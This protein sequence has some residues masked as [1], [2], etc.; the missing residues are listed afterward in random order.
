LTRNSRDFEDVAPW[1]AARGRR[2]LAVDVRG[3]GRS[4]RDPNPLNYQPPVYAGDV[5]SLMMQAGVGRAVFVGTSMGGLITMTLA[6][7]NPLAVAAAVLND[8][9]PELSPVGLTRIMGYVG[10]TAPVKTW[11]EAADY[12][13]ATNGVAFPNAGPEF[14]DAFARRIFRDGP[15][16]PELDY[17]PAITAPFKAAPTGPAPDLWPIFAALAQNRPTLL[18]RG[19]VS[20][21]IDRDIA[22]RMRLAAPT[23]EY[24]EVPDVGHAPMLSEPEAQAALATF[25]DTAP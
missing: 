1:I 20:D 2:V 25:L 5:V 18:V 4:E 9:G 16:G 6:A 17:D 10:Q 15:D 22:A 21:L 24:A 19:G 23:M 14:W 7:T 11:A 12:A 8:V 13:R 3:R